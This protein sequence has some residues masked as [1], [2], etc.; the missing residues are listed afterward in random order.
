MKPIPPE[1]LSGPFSRARAL[2]LG[3]TS[4]MLQSK[5]FARVVPGVWRSSDHEMTR[6]DWLEAATLVLPVSAHLTGI[7]RLQQLGL[8]FGP[9]MPLHFVIEG[10]HHLAYDEIFLHR[11]KKLPPTDA[12]GVSVAASYIAYCTKAR[13]IDAIQV[14][15]WLLRNKHTTLDEIRDLG[16]CGL[17]RDGAYEAVWTLEHLDGRSRSLKESETRAVLE[18]AGLPRPEV[19]V[20]LPIDDDVVVISDLVYRQW[21]TVVEYDGAQHQEDRV[22]YVADIDRYAVYRGH[23]ISYVQVTKEKL[24][25][26]RTLVGEVFRDLVRRGYDGPPPSFGERWRMLFGSCS[27]A[28]GPKAERFRVAR[29]RAIDQSAVS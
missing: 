8:D 26:A 10:D 24:D 21:R 25:H 1:L 27:A 17:W 20:S 22:Q 18:F 5:R 29:Q 12:C 4:R 2:E 16:L 7:T 28:V 9:P 6:D 13:V 14:G 3:V 19:N 15:D 11:T 23:G